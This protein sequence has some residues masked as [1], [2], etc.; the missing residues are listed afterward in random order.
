MDLV[1]RLRSLS[2][3]A[4]NL[5][6]GRALPLIIPLAGGLGIRVEEVGDRRAVATLPLKY[7][8]KNHV[9]SVYFGAQM[10]LAE[11]TM[12]LLLFKLFPPGPYGMLVKRVEADFLAKA[13][14]KLRAV[15]ELPPDVAA[16]LARVETS[17]DGKA[18]AW[19]PVTLT[20][21]E[22][23]VTTVRFLAAVKKFNEG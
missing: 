12:G 3:A 14:G 7:R 1:E 6:M 18:E 21:R 13:K 8:T 16:E 11:L 19:V 9:G 17:A 22:G 20:T 4:A 23:E 15:C 10:T 2:P 5:V